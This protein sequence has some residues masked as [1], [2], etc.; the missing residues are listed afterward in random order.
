MRVAC[1]Y[2]PSFPLQVLVRNAPHLAG[3]A[4]AVSDDAPRPRI[5]AVSRAAWESGVRPGMTPAHARAMAPGVIVEPADFAA[6]RA[7]VD[8]LADSLLAASTAVDTGGDAERAHKAVFVGVPHGS[9]GATFGDK[10]IATANRQGLR[11]RV[12]IADDRFTAWAA[13]A[14]PAR[15]GDPAHADLDGQAPLFTQTCK[16]VPRGGSAAFLAPLP[17]TL[18]PLEDDVRHVLAS[19]DVRSIGDFAALPP[20]TVGR[21]WTESGV[22]L[23]E[24]ARGAGPTG[25]TRFTPSGTIA[26][27]LLLER[28][29]GE[30]DPIAFML[31]PVID[32]VAERLRG[33]GRAAVGISIRLAGGDERG[34]GARTSLPL[35]LPNAT[36]SSRSLLDA[37]RAAL[38]SAPL[39]H[40]VQ[41]ATVEV[42]A[43]TE[44]EVEELEL[45]T[46][47]PHRRTRRGKR[48]RGRSRQQALPLIQR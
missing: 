45:F 35:R 48:G 46:T 36:A 25:L 4:V 38:I 19:L 14:V 12:G 11:A 22:D 20:P 44:P 9:R 10:L 34:R 39:T 29:V 15:T 23:H 3:K 26:E 30:V 32:R 16:T 6:N 47:R 17:M 13:A 43:E 2:I 40:A 37:V 7:A 18:L 24:L 8:A 31:H 33:R 41:S 42:V 28:E 1:V 21:R 27:T 5:V